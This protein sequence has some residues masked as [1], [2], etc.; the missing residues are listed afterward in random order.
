MKQLNRINGYEFTNAFRQ[1]EILFFKLKDKKLRPH[2]NAKRVKSGV[3]REGEGEGHKHTV[4]G[5]AQLTM[6]PETMAATPGETQQQPSQGVVEVGPKGATVTHPEH[7]E[8]KLPPGKYIVQ[9][10]KEA[11]GKHTTQSVK[12]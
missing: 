7:G 6:F 3:I 10:Q 12:D 2:P 5:D 8:V 1:G 9:T 11:T 4:E